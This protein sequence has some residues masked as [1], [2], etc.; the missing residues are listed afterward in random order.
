MHAIHAALHAARPDLGAFVHAHSLYG[1]TWS[2]LGRLLDPITQD[3]CA[4]FNRHAVH[5]PFTGLIDDPEGGKTI[6][7]RLGSGVGIIL[8]NHRHL[9]RS[10]EEA[11][12]IAR[13]PACLQY[14]SFRTMECF[15]REACK[16]QKL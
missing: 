14:G 2:S 12:G 3:A 5:G 10:V 15:V 6:A 7:T 4:I 16:I 9:G 1:R 11:S 8:Q 13:D